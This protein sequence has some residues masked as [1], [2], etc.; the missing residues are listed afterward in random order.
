MPFAKSKA[1]RSPMQR[2]TDQR[3]SLALAGLAA[4]AVFSAAILR[5]RRR[6]GEAEFGQSHAEA[7][8]T[9]TEPTGSGPP[10]A[11]EVPPAASESDAFAAA[12]AATATQADHEAPETTA[13]NATT[14]P[15]S[16]EAASTSISDPATGELSAEEAS[17]LAVL[18][19]SGRNDDD[20][21]AIAVAASLERETADVAGVLRKLGAEG[22]VEGELYTA[23][24]EKI[25][26][27]TERG[28]R[29]LGAQ[30]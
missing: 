10:P 21:T 11:A 30:H 20:R 28:V 22:V 26:A 23:S 4:G 9:P 19:Q 7:A 6:G 18:A 24:G 16:A 14:E 29:R 1:R 5:R 12:E 13:L 8:E 3:R 2:L 25:W 15:V 17:I 27:V